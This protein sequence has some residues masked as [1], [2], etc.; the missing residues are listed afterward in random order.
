MKGDKVPDCYRMLIFDPKED[1]TA[2]E[3]AAVLSF[4]WA[5]GLSEDG[6][7]FPIE[8]HSEESWAVI[9]WNLQEQFPLAVRHLRGCSG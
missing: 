5:T 4:A 3:L 1:I 7:L 9:R 6:K 8:V 2:P